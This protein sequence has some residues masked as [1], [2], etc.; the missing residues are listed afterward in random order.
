MAEITLRFNLFSGFIS[1]SSHAMES[2]PMPR[3]GPNL[4]RQVRAEGGLCSCS[5]IPM[6]TVT[7]NLLVGNH[8]QPKWNTF[9]DPFWSD[10]ISNGLK[11][12]NR[13]AT[14]SSSSGQGL[15]NRKE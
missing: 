13:L 1:S 8:I 4:D 10:D 9:W 3:G 7:R 12:V 5:E 2:R 6:L 14:C 11:V 15:S